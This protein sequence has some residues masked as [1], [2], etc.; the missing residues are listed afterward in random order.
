MPFLEQDVLGLD[1]AMDDV[2]AMGVIERLGHLM[3]DLHGIDHR[4]PV[5]PGEAQ[6]ERIVLDERHNVE[7][8]PAG[9][10]VVVQL[11]DVGV[12][13]AGGDLDLAQKALGTEGRAQLGAQHFDGDPALE[14]QVVGEKDHGHPAAANLALHGVAAR[15]RRCEPR[16]KL[17]HG[18]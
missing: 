4:Q 2:V 12:L 14:A 5:V 1:V 11:E 10:A 18:L 6:P 9:L 15:K 17:V 3:R 13:Q 8:Q 16:A 7:Q